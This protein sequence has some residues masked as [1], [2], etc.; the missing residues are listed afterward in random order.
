[1][2]AHSVPFRYGEVGIAGGYACTEVEFPS[3]DCSFGGV[4]TVGVGWNKLVVINVLFE[5]VL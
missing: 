3:L 4:A 5:G 2:L 1:M